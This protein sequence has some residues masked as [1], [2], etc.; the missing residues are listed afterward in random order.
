VPHGVRGA[1][2]TVTPS[3]AVGHDGRGS[4]CFQFFLF[5]LFDSDGGKLYLKIVAFDEI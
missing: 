4:V 2:G 3:T 1:R 5:L